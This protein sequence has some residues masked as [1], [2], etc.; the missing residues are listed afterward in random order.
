LRSHC[1]GI[2]A[3]STIRERERRV[4]AAVMYEPEKPLVI[5]EVAVSKPGPHEVLIRLIGCA[6]TTGAGGH[7]ARSVVMFS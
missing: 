1:A 2:L 4:K 3:K 6:V 5:E 7:I